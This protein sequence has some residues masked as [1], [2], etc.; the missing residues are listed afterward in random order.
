ERQVRVR[1]HERGQLV[2]GRL[3]DLRFGARH[4]GSLLQLLGSY[5]ESISTGYRR[6]IALRLIFNVGVTRPDSGCHTSSSTANRLTCEVRARRALACSTR[7]AMCSRRRGWA[8]RRGTSSSVTPCADAQARAS[9]GS[10]VSS[11]V[12]YG[13][14]SPIAA[15]GPST[16]Q[17]DRRAFSICAGDMF[18]PAELMISSFLRST[19]VR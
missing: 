4:R 1:P 10:R 14:R 17:A 13:R 6:S 7:S 12:T 2:V 15:T 18:F 5:R 11:A 16:W 9:S 19:I 3:Q 8:A